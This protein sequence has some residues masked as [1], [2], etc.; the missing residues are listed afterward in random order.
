MPAGIGAAASTPERHAPGGQPQ[1][2]RVV[3]EGDELEGLG[4]GGLGE[5]GQI[6]HLEVGRNVELVLD[7][8]LHDTS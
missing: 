5:T 3:V 6:R 4:T 1:I 7:L 8:N 2:R